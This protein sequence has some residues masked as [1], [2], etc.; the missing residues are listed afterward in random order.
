MRAFEPAKVLVIEDEHDV[1]DLIREILVRDGLQVDHVDSA[2]AALAVLG[3]Q[4]YA[5]ILADL[6]MPGLGGRELY[7]RILR[8]QPMLASRIAFVTGDTMSPSARSFLDTANRPCLEKPL[9][10]GELRRLART[11]LSDLSRGGGS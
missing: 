2:E 6:N 11:V 4:S 8:D 7:R 5:L 9:A 10:P 1:A 3:K